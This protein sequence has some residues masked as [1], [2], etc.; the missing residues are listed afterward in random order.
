MEGFSNGT[1]DFETLLSYSNATLWPTPP[2]VQVHLG[3]KECWARVNAK[4]KP[5]DSL[6]Y[7]CNNSL[8]AVLVAI[9]ENVYIGA[10]RPALFA[11]RSLQRALLTPQV[12]PG[13]LY[14]CGRSI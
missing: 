10:A 14:R 5:G 12:H 6:G 7:G 3:A 9:R 1:R 13:S 8:A 2:L 4:P 11:S